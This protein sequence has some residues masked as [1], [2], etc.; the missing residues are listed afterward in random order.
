MGRAIRLI[1]LLWGC[2]RVTASAVAAEPIDFVEDV[3]P[4]LQR[5]CESC[6][7]PQKQKSGLR[8]DIRQAAF[9]GGELYGPS[10]VPGKLE[11]SPLWL[12]VADPQAD[13]KMPPEGEPLSAAELSVLKRWIE[14]GA[15]W[16]PGVDT[17]ELRDL[18]DHWSFHPVQPVPLPVVEQRDWPRSGLDHFILARLEA[19]GLAPA[20]PADPAAWLRR[21]TLDLTGLPPSPAEVAEFLTDHSDSARVRVVDRLLASPR[22]GERWGQHWL[23]VV[24][25][26]DTHGFEVNTERPHAWPYRDYV[27]EAFNR[28]LPYDQFI[29]EQLVGDALGADA[30]TGFLVTASVLLPGQIGQ[31]EPSKRLARQ[32]ALDEIVVNIG[33]TFLGLTIG[34]ARCHDHKFDPVSQRDYF[35]MQ[36]CVAGVEYGDRELQTPASA[37]RRKQAETWQAELRELQAQ[38]RKFVPLARLQPPA[39]PPTDP[40]LNEIRFEP[41]P[42]RFVRFTIHDANLHPTLGLIEPCLDELEVFTAEATPRNVALASAGTK[43]TASGSR[44]SASHRLEFLNDGQYGN[45]RSWMSNES[46]RGWVQLEFPEPVIIDRVVWGRDRTGQLTDR[47]PTAY[48]LEIGSSADEWEVV[49]E[50][51]P[52]R[53]AVNFQENVDRFSPVVAKAVRLTTLATNNLEPCIDEFEVLSPA[54]ENVA[55]ASRGVIARASGEARVRDRHALEYVHDGQ[56]GN[57]RSWLAN[58]T[59]GAWV[60]LEFPVP[61][62]I[63]RV[64]WG[65]DRE[66]KFQDRLPTDYRIEVQLESEEWLTVAT[67]LDRQPFQPE[68]SAGQRFST[69]GLPAHEA[70]QLAPLLQQQQQLEASIKEALQPDLVFAGTFRAPDEIRLLRRG[71]PEQPQ[72]VVAPAGLPFLGNLQLSVETTEQDRRRALAD[73]IADPAHPL[74]ARVMVNRIWQ[75]HFGTGLV[76]TPNDFGWNGTPPTHPE[77]LD[78]LAQEFVNS[79]WSIKSLHRLIVLSAT[80]GQG[81]EHNA[82][83]AERDADVRL[84]WRYPSRR[85]EGEAIRDSILEVSGQLNLEMGGRGFNLFRQRGGLSGF[86][87]VETPTAA[88]RRRMIYAHKV[89]RERDAVF[90]AFDCPDAGQSAPGRKES[91]TPIQALNLFNSPFVIAQSAAFAERLTESAGEDQSAQ[92]V[93]AWQLT[94][95]R[96]PQPEE[97]AEAL[98]LVQSYGL[99]MLGR[100]LFNSNEFL[101]IP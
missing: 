68:R 72:D 96:D 95:G 98:P 78:W 75:G 65:R 81:G 55:L 7:G 29:R 69:A 66:G 12:F 86:T 36:A 88:E 82:A 32:D 38:L 37:A 56:Y 15:V 6:H 60:E 43:A 16:P 85:L 23:D 67:A 2:C 51:L 74:T 47:L 46:G 100:V 26:A 54:G 9:K 64:V 76:D 90:G 13:L 28:D 10:V 52:L 63:E 89:R 34:C 18:R 84:L 1:L 83:A 14:Q 33:Q 79:G 20:R 31:D 91:T 21:V 25:Y 11:E 50:L 87:P 97:L 71:D 53:P 17:A 4:I 101:F 45:A 39:Q 92:I 49:A 44:T 59:Q 8:L 99:P 48:T 77:L 94:L 57:S 22:Y 3:R 19:E 41:Q 35:A 70:R 24:R 42:A 62:L 40:K 30:A 5:H 58:S 27:I 80:Y 93:L 73:W 61:A